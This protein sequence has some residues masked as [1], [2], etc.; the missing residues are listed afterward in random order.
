MLLLTH[1]FCWLRRF[2]Q[3]AIASAQVMVAIVPSEKA[4]TDEKTLPPTL[5]AERAEKA[6]YPNWMV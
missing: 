6:Q 4:S 3:R 5:S 2:F 1:C